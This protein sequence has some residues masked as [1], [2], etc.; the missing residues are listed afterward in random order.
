VLFNLGVK[1]PTLDWQSGQ[2]HRLRLINIAASD[3]IGVVLRASEKQLQWRAIA[4]DG[5]DP[6]PEQ[7]QMQNALQSTLPG[8]TYDFAILSISR[9]KPAICNWKSSI[10]G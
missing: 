3:G 4:R 2:R 7:A 6:R 10:Q 9:L 5:A 1:P 8:E